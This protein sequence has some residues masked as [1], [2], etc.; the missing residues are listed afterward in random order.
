M[1][2]PIESDFEITISEAGAEATFNPTQSHYSFY[3]LADPEDIARLGPLSPRNV[4]HAGPT[5]DTDDYR[6]EEV[7]AMALRLALIAVQ[8]Q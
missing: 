7:Q 5:G 3:R 4:R 6:S 2:R 1:K 8:G